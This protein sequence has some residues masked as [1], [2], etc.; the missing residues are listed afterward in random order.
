MSR[1]TG[2]VGLVNNMGARFTSSAA[3]FSP[4]MEEL[5]ARGL[6]YLDD[7]SSNRSLAPQLA[8]ANHVPFARAAM[9]ID[10]NPAAGPIRAALDELEQK[11]RAEGSAI[12]IATALPVTITTLAEWSRDLA[13]RG[14]KLVP[15][16]A[17]MK[18]AS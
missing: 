7:G 18:T 13:E 3:D 11:A 15:V 14:I 5:G 10:I 2:Y 17:L 16:S 8:E 12:G 6:G 9:P 1:F 4:M